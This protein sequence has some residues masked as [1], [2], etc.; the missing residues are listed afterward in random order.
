MRYVVCTIWLFAVLTGCATVKTPPPLFPNPVLA[1]P[2]DRDVFW[3]QLVAVV[4][5]YFDIKSEDR[6]R[7]VDN[8]LTLGRID[9]VPELGATLLEPWRKDSVGFYERLESTYQTIRRRALI[10]VVPTDNGGYMV[11]VAV[12]KELEDLRRPDHAN[13]GDATFR[14]DDS[15][16][17][18]NDQTQG[19]TT[20]LDS[21][22]TYGR[23]R[24]PIGPQPFT[25]GWIPLG[26]DA[27]LEQRMIADLLKRLGAPGPGECATPIP[28]QPMPH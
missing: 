24:G 14:N 1:P 13:A 15:L 2:I 3:D 6:V 26:R 12:Y 16:D 4:D 8:M 23:A 18:Y 10:Q 9:T 28:I 25:L 11:D 19:P 27:V 20:T 17:R 21:F 7:L 22:P 5:D